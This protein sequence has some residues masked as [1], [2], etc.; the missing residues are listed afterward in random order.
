MPRFS[1]REFAEFLRLTPEA[2]YIDHSAPVSAPMAWQPEIETIDRQKVIKP[3]A[4][5]EH[6]EQV[7]FFAWAD[8]MTARWPELALLYAVPNG[9]YRHPATAV[10]LKNEGVKAGVP[11]IFLPVPLHHWHGLYI[12]MKRADRSNHPS[13]EQRIWIEELRRQGYCVAVCYGCEA[14]I[15]AFTAY[16][17]GDVC[18]E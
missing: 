7:A 9:G 6:A 14:A 17:R 15:N 12:E 10:M 16:M 13:A 11:D 1:E 3:A 18:N 2:T 5:T 8:A 4:P